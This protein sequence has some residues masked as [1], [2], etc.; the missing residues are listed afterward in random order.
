MLLHQ[1]ALWLLLLLIIIIIMVL[2]LV[3]TMLMLQ[4]IVSLGLINGLE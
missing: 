4:S 1:L 2:M 3:A